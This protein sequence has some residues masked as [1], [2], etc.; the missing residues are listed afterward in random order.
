M[1]A[2]WMTSWLPVQGPAQHIGDDRG[3]G[4]GEEMMQED[5]DETAEW[6]KLRHER[7][8]AE[9]LP[10]G[11]VPPHL[12]WAL[13]TTGLK[14]DEARNTAAEVVAAIAEA[15]AEAEYTWEKTWQKH[16]RT[17]G[18]PVITT[19][20]NDKEGGGVCLACRERYTQLYW[21]REFN[22]PAAVALLEKCTTAYAT[23]VPASV[24]PPAAGRGGRVTR[25]DA[26]KARLNGLKTLA[27]R[28]A[29]RAGITVCHECAQRTVCEAYAQYEHMGAAVRQRA[30]EARE[31]IQKTAAEETTRMEIEHEGLQER[32][33]S[34]TR[35]VSAAKSDTSTEK[36]NREAQQQEAITHEDGE[37]EMGT[38][39]NGKQWMARYSNLRPSERNQFV[40]EERVRVCAAE[41][42]E[43]VR[44]ASPT[45]VRAADMCP[46]R[47]THSSEEVV[48]GV[49]Y[50]IV[51]STRRSGRGDG[52][53]STVYWMVPIPEGGGNGDAQQAVARRFEIGPGQHEDVD[54]DKDRRAQERERNSAATGAATA[55]EKDTDMGGKRARVNQTPPPP[56]A[57]PPPSN[58][59]GPT[60]TRTTMTATTMP[61]T[62]GGRLT[63]PPTTAP[64]PPA[65]PAELQRMADAAAATAL[66]LTATAATARLMAT[67]SVEIA[68][69]ALRR[70]DTDDNTLAPDEMDTE[71]LI[72]TESDSETEPDGMDPGTSTDTVTA[73]ETGS[74]AAGQE[75]LRVQKIAP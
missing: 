33:G 21:M 49:R 57:G 50:T 5:D 2:W 47:E 53:E 20:I 37:W 25:D 54:R 73:T 1:E 11:L 17:I 39:R 48:N 12:V 35:A 64:P 38:D 31:Q 69:A 28:H 68:H 15:A 19:T 22:G 45:Q 13:K 34:M 42:N 7:E 23:S 30:T 24:R 70:Q 51:H 40:G 67:I 66:D 65:G 6:A 61:P 60:D 8:A 29:Q 10:D 55:T 59:T 46:A 27:W 71:T 36:D 44:V 74:R 18:T 9:P 63:P 32:T 26:I 14:S 56:P 58:A 43:L 4:G 41:E 72:A 16:E 3:I 52:G 75:F 62:A